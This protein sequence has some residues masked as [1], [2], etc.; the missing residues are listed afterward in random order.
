V[1]DYIS[2]PSFHTHTHTHTHTHNGDDTL[3][4]YRITNLKVDCFPKAVMESSAP[5]ALLS[6]AWPNCLRQPRCSY[7]VQDTDLQN[8]VPY[9]NMCLKDSTTGLNKIMKILPLI[10]FGFSLVS[11]ECV[12]R[13]LITHSLLGAQHRMRV[14]IRIKVKN[15]L[16]NSSLEVVLSVPNNTILFI[17]SA[18]NYGKR[19][20]QNRPRRPR[21]ETNI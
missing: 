18:M 5:A 10:S 19:S 16:D 3:P 11:D 14:Y 21:E 6:Q 15:F 1:F 2:F 4:S 7:S 20:P 13:V 9:V 12:Y 17:P 8:T